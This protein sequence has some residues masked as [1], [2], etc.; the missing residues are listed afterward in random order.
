VQSHFCARVSKE[1]ARRDKIF[2]RF[3]VMMH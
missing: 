1:A 3:A 2:L